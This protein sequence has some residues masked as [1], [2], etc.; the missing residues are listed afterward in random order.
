MV[1]RAELLNTYVGDF[2]LVDFLGAG[3]MGE[4]YRAVNT[5]TGLVAAVKVLTEA[6]DPGLIERFFNEARIQASIQH[7][8]IARFYEFHQLNSHPCIV[9]EYIHGQTLAERIKALGRLPMSETIYIFQCA[10][11]AVGYIHKLGIVHRDIKA[12][13]IKL[14][15]TGQVKLLDFG[16]AK[17]ESTAKMTR[18]GGVVGTLQYLSPEQLK[19]GQADARSDLW[20]LGIMLYEMTTGQVPFEA[21]TI[22]TLYEKIMK[23]AYTP[24]AVLNPLVPR[25]IESI[26]AK[27]LKKKPGDRYQTAEDLLQDVGR[28]AATVVAPSS[29]SH[30]P[31]SDL[32]T[33]AKE[34]WRLLA[35]ATGVLVLVIALV[36]FLARPGPAPPA[37]P[38][39]RP[40][41]PAPASAV[42]P[43]PDAPTKTLE[44]QLT[45]G[46][47][48]VWRDGTMIGTVSASVPLRFSAKVGENISLLLKQEGYE[49][50][51]PNRFTVESHWPD[52][53]IIGTFSMKKK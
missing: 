29:G 46:A 17:A 14:S 48:Q 31:Q 32:L 11:E 37:D 53:K 22:G 39:P 43:A 44:V 28:L 25:E 50:L 12:N 49:D 41:P 52:V 27:C 3:G 40:K 18:T 47:A 26:V 20:A 24:A 34:H 21:D 9:M 1:V 33:K 36:V 35:S 16:I 15:S 45:E 51:S 30:A 10:V 38:N 42:I 7:P 8:N 13:N 4:V 23:G 6:A 2:R 19:G 5:R